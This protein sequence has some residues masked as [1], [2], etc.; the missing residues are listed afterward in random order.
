M[1]QEQHHRINKNIEYHNEHVKPSNGL[2]QALWCLSVKEDAH[3]VWAH[4]DNK[5]IEYL[6]VVVSSFLE[7]FDL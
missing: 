7:G 3:L 1:I 5:L 2:Q 6:N 4:Q